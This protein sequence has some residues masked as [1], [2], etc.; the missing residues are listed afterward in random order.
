M[1][2]NYPRIHHSVIATLTTLIHNKLTQQYILKSEKSLSIKL[3]AT[4]ETPVY[5]HTSRKCKALSGDLHH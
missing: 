2:V 1:N 4:Y 5:I 3:F